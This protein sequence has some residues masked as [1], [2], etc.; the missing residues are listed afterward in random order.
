MRNPVANLLSSGT[1]AIA[2]DECDRR[3]IHG[4]WQRSSLDTSEITNFI[5]QT[6]QKCT[7]NAANLERK[8][9]LIPIII[10]KADGTFLLMTVVHI[11]TGTVTTG[12]RYFSSDKRIS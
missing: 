1:V 5:I 8:K 3:M 7:K 12:S 10:Q 4:T 2:L 6:E 11:R 9:H